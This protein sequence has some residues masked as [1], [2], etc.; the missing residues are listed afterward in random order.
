VAQ[1]WAVVGVETGVHWPTTDTT[2]EFDGHQLTLRPETLDRAPTVIMQCGPSLTLD[3]GLRVIRRFLSS[4]SWVHGAPIREIAST[5]GSA[6]FWIGKGAGARLINPDFHADYLPAPTS[7]KARFAFAL[8]RE[9][10]SV[11][12]VAYQFLGFAKI[13]NTLYEK[14]RDQ[15]D[16]I[17]RNIDLTVDHRA[18]ERLA[19]LRREISDVGDYLYTSGRCAVAHAYNTP[20]VDPEDPDDNRRMY[21]DLP[22]IRALAEDLIER[23]LGIKSAQTV[24]REH[25]YELGGF[26]LLIGEEAAA[27][28]KNLQP[29]DLKSKSP[30]PRLSIRLRKQPIF[31]ALERLLVTGSPI[32]GDGGI[33]LHCE[34]EDGLVHAE[35]FLDFANERLVFGPEDKVQIRDDGTAA[36]IR[37]V[38]DYLRFRKYYYMNGELEVYDGEHDTL[39]GRCDPYL[40][41]NVDLIGTAQSI[42]KGIEELEKEARRREDI[43]ASAEIKANRQ[44][45]EAEPEED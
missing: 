21:K 12:S 29:I 3:D 9:A 5:G 28:L 17:N 22:L 44:P 14:S 7:E 11:N 10:L 15:K 16:W 25:L 39:L 42:D 18:K 6:P 45:G 13:L 1:Q 8:Y 4:L 38:I 24:W 35:L 23:E 2:I 19:E 37:H 43:S 31:P 41:V 30:W 36:T 34:S 40:P 32:V 26:R 27:R 20:V 33:Q